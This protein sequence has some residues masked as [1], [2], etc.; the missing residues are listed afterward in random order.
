[1]KSSLFIAGLALGIG[2]IGLFYML[3][4]T[5]KKEKKKKKLQD[6]GTVAK[7]RELEHLEQSMSSDQVMEDS[8]FLWI[9]HRLVQSDELSEKMQI[10][11]LLKVCS[12]QKQIE[13]KKKKTLLCFCSFFL[14]I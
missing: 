10:V 3:S 5:K 9:A 2:A 1:M 6:F 8:L 12:F 13:M 11:S 4:A 14:I 7:S